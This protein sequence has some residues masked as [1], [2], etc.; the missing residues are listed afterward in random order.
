MAINTTTMISRDFF[1]KKELQRNRCD[2]EYDTYRE[3]SDTEMNY[4]RVYITHH[5]GAPSSDKW[6]RKYIT[7]D[8]SARTQEN[9]EHA[10]ASKPAQ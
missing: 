10:N 7:Q 6:V 1:F 3:T 4:G 2:G 5:N 8:I 9:G